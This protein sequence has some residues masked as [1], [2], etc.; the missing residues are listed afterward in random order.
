MYFRQT[1]GPDSPNSIDL[2]YVLDSQYDGPMAQSIP[3]D[4]GGNQYVPNGFKLV[5]IVRR[6]KYC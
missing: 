1:E 4:R 6:P 2:V 5:D 3:V